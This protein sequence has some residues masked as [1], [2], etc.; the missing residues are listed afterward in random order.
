MRQTWHEHRATLSALCMAVSVTIKVNTDQKGH[1][2]DNGVVAFR[3][4]IAP[5]DAPVVAKLRL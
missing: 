5:D 2:T 3:D 4:L 1:P